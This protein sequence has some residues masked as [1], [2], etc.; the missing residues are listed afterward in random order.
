MNDSAFLLERNIDA[1]DAFFENYEEKFYLKD[2][3]KSSSQ[4]KLKKLKRA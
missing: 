1:F 4:V 3:T 2:L